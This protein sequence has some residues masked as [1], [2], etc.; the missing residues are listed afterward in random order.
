[1]PATTCAWRFCNHPALK[2]GVTHPDHELLA[3]GEHPKWP[4]GVQVR[5]REDGGYDLY[6]KRRRS[7][8]DIK[9]DVRKRR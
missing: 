3:T 8:P 2:E 7:D 1:M 6:P 5:E 9:P 4:L